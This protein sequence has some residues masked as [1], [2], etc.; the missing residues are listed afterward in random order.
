MSPNWFDKI[1]SRAFDVTAF[2]ILGLLFVVRPTTLVPTTV[3]LLASVFIFFKSDYRYRFY[4]LFIQGPYTQFAIAILFW[5]IV[6]LCLAMFH[7]ENNR[8][9]FPENSL[10]MVMALSLLIISV[11]KSSFKWFFLGIFIAG[12]ASAYWAFKSWPWGV[13][14]R[15]EGTTNNPIHF[16]NLSA[17]VMM[18]SISIVITSSSVIGRLRL[19]F[20]L[21]ALGGFLGAISSLTRSSFMVVLLCFIPLMNLSVKRGVTGRL[22]GFFVGV[23]CLV[24]AM[25]LSQPFVR[26]KLRISTLVENVQDLDNG[27]Y[28]SSVGARIVMWK[29]S[30]LIFTENPILGVGPNRFKYE[31]KKKMDDGSIPVT[32]LYNQPHSDVMHSLSSGGGVKFLAYIGIL[33]TPLVFFIRRF[34]DAASSI[35]SRLISIMGM[36]IIGA[37]F[38][39]GLTNSNFDLQIYSTTYAV[40]V[41]VLAK[42]SMQPESES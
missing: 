3:L 37:Y 23:I 38:L 18:L 16:G 32:D 7:Y 28:I 26:D 14:T 6:N 4:A 24:T 35:R 8:I 15:A 21:S 9:I 42:L 27:D 5:F 2:T 22:V 10:K 11:R 29:T 34:R 17:I 19:F 36:Q 40:L 12:L 13:M 1:S 25:I 20:L 30:W 31:M 33:I 39:T 41:C